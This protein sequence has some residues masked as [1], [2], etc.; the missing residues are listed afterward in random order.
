MGLAERWTAEPEPVDEAILV[1][2]GRA[3]PTSVR[4]VVGR[5]VE[6]LAALVMLLIASPLLVVGMVIVGVSDG[7]PIFFGHQRVGKGGA[8]FRCWKL[9]TMRTDAEERLW[10]DPDLH[11]RYIENGFKLPNSQDPRIIPGGAWLRRMY[12]DELP[13][14]WNVIVGD[15]SLVGPRPIVEKEI[16]MFGP[17]ASRLFARRPG[18]FGEWTSLGPNR[19]PYPQRVQVEMEY[20]DDPSL[21]RTLRILARSVATVIR[22][23]GEEG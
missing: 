20:M 23:Q 6:V 21:L 5:A 13:Q 11:R 8:H 9:R 4:A 1:L 12:L 10:A 19:P 15:M 17:T 16:E 22:G 2:D 3:E 14:L 18:V 7:F